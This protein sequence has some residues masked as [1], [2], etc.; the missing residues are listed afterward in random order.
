MTFYPETASPQPN[1]RTSS[2]RARV[3]RG[4]QRLLDEAAKFR[5]RYEYLVILRVVAP[6][7]VISRFL[8]EDD[9]R[10]AE[11]RERTE[12]V[13]TAL[14]TAG[15]TLKCKKHQAKDGSKYVFVF[16]TADRE[17]LEKEADRVAIEHWLQEDGIGAL[18]ARQGGG[19]DQAPN[20]FHARLSQQ[21]CVAPLP[22]APERT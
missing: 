7:G 6:A 5:L 9:K 19:G 2:P 3:P 8:T 17:R 1:S 22:A 14:R 12:E 18:H 20:A 13:I 11:G 10:L 21:T 15:L 4:P 16:V